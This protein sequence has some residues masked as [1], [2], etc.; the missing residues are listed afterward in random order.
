MIFD[1]RIDSLVAKAFIGP[2]I[3]AFVIAEFVLVMQ[4]L[5][6][7][8]D[9]ITGKGIGIFEILELVFYFSLTL[10][11]TAIPITILLASVF[12]FGNMS[13][14]FQLTS[15]KSAG[16]S[17]FRIV[18]MG[19]VIGILTALLSVIASNM[20]VPKA[21]YVF[22]KGFNSIKKHKPALVIEEGMFNEDFT[23]YKIYV[24]SKAK[25]GKSISDIKIYDQ[26]INSRQINLITAQSGEMS[27]SPDGKLF[28]MTLF[29][30][31]QIRELKENLSKNKGVKKYP[32]TKSTFKKWEKSFDMSE[33]QIKKEGNIS[34]TN[35]FDL[36]NTPQLLYSIDSVSSEVTSLNQRNIYNYDKMVHINNDEFD[37]QPKINSSMNKSASAT[38]KDLETKAA[39]SKYNKANISSDKPTVRKT[40]YTNTGKYKSALS[41]SLDIETAGSFLNLIKKKERK[42]ILKTAYTKANHVNNQVLTNEN[43][44]RINL[45][46]KRRFI[47]K[48]HQQYSQA[49]ICI[50]FLF[51]GA[52]LGSIIRKGGYGFPL[53]ISII[54]FMLFIIMRIMGSRLQGSGVLNPYIAAWLPNIVLLPFA[55]IFTYKAI[56]DSRFNF[57]ALF[58]RF[59]KV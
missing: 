58:S 52:P 38:I 43:K 29:D 34:T 54:F 24:G 41:D 56:R 57:Q 20:I 21:N 2:Y 15:L 6:K 40:G 59:S 13:E 19:I 11:P 30:G 10:I 27:T 36:M 49:L 5:W 16:I 25:D 17:F 23:N 44:I 51:I 53:L 9:D 18:R 22:F 26:N 12:V 7:Y 39:A 4:F 1:K 47:Y 3:M 33:F 8:I 14:T 46:K 48:L 37:Q 55:V 50:L 45:A 32:M 42:S 28:I 35:S 31:E